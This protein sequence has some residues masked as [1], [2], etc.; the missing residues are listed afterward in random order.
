MKR[1]FVALLAL[2][3]IVLVGSAAALD[4]G[5]YT[6]LKMRNTSA[7]SVARDP[8]WATPGFSPSGFADSVVFRRGVQTRTVYDTT[9]AF[10]AN[11]YPQPPN[12][13][14][15]TT[16]AADSILPWIIVRIE[17]D[18]VR[19][20]TDPLLFT[21]NSVLGGGTDSV[22][23]AVEHSP[24]GGRTWFSCSG[25][26]TY[27]FDIVFMTSGQDGLQSPT[28]IGVEGSPGEDSASIPIKSRVLTSNA[29]INNFN[30]PYIGEPL[31]IIIGGAYSGQF[32]ISVGH[33]PERPA[34]VY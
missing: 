13:S 22:R 10:W 19:T 11:S 24:D 31:R 27:R 14:D 26:P 32:K 4:F 28:L 3:S 23:I 12:M 16:A 34:D 7:S 25:T 5:N 29:Y 6:V 21:G 8:N 15:L 30:L 33:W 20:A 17:Q 18:S 1:L 9:A 2:A